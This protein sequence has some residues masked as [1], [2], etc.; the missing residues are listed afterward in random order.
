MSAMKFDV[1]KIEGKK[2]NFGKVV[3]WA[4]G[5][6]GHINKNCT[7]GRDGLENGPN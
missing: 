6:S 4:C 2:K 7:K 1:E 3:C 5:Q